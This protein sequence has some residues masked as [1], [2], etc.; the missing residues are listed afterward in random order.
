MSDIYLNSSYWEKQSNFTAKIKLQSNFIE[1]TPRHGCST[2]NLKYIFR[3]HF[4]KNTS[5]G[6]LLEHGLFD[7][8]KREKERK[9]KEY[10]A[11]TRENR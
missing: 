10:A 8:K 4:P 1:I 2:V 9:E 11:A 6:L 5:G 7:L 3:T